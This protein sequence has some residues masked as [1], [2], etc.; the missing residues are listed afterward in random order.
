MMAAVNMNK[1][2]SQDKQPTFVVLISANA[3]WRIVR[4]HFIQN[5]IRKSPF[6]EWFTNRYIDNPEIDKP[7]IFLHGGW[8]KVAAAASA[9]YAINRWNPQLIINIGTCGGFKGVVG[10]GEIL[11]VQKTII[12]DIFEQMGD[13]GEHIEFYSTEID[14]AWLE[15]VYPIPVRSSLLVSGDRDLF[16]HDI[17]QLKTKYGAIAGD[18]ES[19]A[20]AWVSGRNRVKCLILRGVT[21]LVGEDGGEA[22]EGNINVF[23]ENT[24]LIME[25]LII[26]LPQWLLKFI[27]YKW[28]GDLEK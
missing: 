2:K 5:R 18:W 19:G 20:I 25:R 1:Y 9:Q 10:K 21:D 23:Y 11:L 16:I 6:G 17:P 13:P 27:K 8:G 28:V 7:V 22:Y 24:Q 12:Y 14:T 26:S 3:E 4:E 15:D